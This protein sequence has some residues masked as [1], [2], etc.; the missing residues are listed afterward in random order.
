M[1]W[2][3][4]FLLCLPKWGLLNLEPKLIQGRDFRM[5]PLHSLQED[6]KKTRSRNI[7]PFTSGQLWG[8]PKSIGHRRTLYTKRN[9]E[10][11]LPNLLKEI[12]GSI[13]K[14]N[15]GAHLNLDHEQP[16]LCFFVG[17]GSREGKLFDYWHGNCHWIWKMTASFQRK[18]PKCRHIWFKGICK[19]FWEQCQPL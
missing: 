4:F 13:M 6:P 1:I 11:Q 14:D 12:V 7:V 2:L 17:L 19:L 3:L 16:A 18:A 15:E 5:L 8:G 9:S 10:A